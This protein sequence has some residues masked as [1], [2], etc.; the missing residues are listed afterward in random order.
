METDSLGLGSIVMRAF[1]EIARAL[2]PL[3]ALGAAACAQDERFPQANSFA[4]TTTGSIPA[5]PGDWSGQPGAS[6]H[7]LMQPDAILASV[8]NFRNC[9]EGMWPAAAARGISRQ[10]F[11]RFASGLE[12]DVKI[13]DFVD[14]QPE[15]TKAFWDYIDLLVTEERIAKGREMLSAHAAAFGRMEQAY[16]V[17]RYVVTAIWGIETKFGAVTGERPVIRSVA[18]LACVGR[19]QAYF[20]DEFLAAL[21]ILH[22]GDIAPVRLK[23]S[24]A[25]AFGLTQFMPTAFKRYAVDFDGDGRRD[26]ATSVPDV[27]AS[28][29]NHLKKVGWQTG[30]TWGYEVVVPQGFNF[31]LADSSRKLTLHEWTRHGITRPSREAFPRPND[32]AHL[33]LP[34]G[35]RGPA[36]LMLDNFHAIMRYNPAEAYALAIG[37]LAD[38]LRGGGAIVQAWPRDERVLTRAERLEFQQHLNRHGFDVGQPNGRFGIKTRAAVRD[39]QARN[40]MIPD[41]FATASILDRLRR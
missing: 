38:R 29:A 10:S 3:V 1:R 25:G 14:A 4:P 13:M 18:T 7:P 21:E 19:R 41:G 33:F 22:R 26:V 23:G 6:G 39:F 28:T 24:W 8:A 15:F 27:I 34:A 2:V 36:F 11:E 40:G 20:K 17:D 35:S 32:R 30:Q 37:H 9:V 5:Q 12:P 16:G 31:M